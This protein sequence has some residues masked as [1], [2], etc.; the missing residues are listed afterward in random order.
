MIIRFNSLRTKG[1]T[2]R[3]VGK[4]KAQAVSHDFIQIPRKPGFETPTA[5]V[6]AIN[7]TMN[8]IIADNSRPK[9]IVS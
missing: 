2:T 4:A 8:D 9:K 6:L 1:A 7:D 5:I 3:T